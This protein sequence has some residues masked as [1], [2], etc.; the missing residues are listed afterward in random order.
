VLLVVT[1]DKA[2]SRHQGGDNMN[3]YELDRER[4]DEGFDRYQQLIVNDWKMSN[5]LEEYESRFGWF[6]NRQPIGEAWFPVQVEESK[7]TYSHIPGDYPLVNGFPNDCITPF[8]SQQAAAALADLLE[9]NGELLP[10]ICDF[11]QYYAFNITR[12]VEALDEECSE[13][14]PYSEL[15]DDLGDDPDFLLVTN[16]A[17]HPDRVA[18]LSIFKLPKR[19]RKNMP[20]VTDRFVERVRDVNLKG[21]AFNL[22]WSSS[23]RVAAPVG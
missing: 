16:F 8:F 12:E 13:F 11:G 17:F 2:V 18:D 22:L 19:N 1:L 20:L 9:G 15:Y 3:V 14:Q 5:K 7:H 23:Q 21:F 4:D 6:E 10:L